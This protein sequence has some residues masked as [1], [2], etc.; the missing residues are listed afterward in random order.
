LRRLID[1]R[2]RFISP[3]ASSALWERTPRC[4]QL[5]TPITDLEP[6]RCSVAFSGCNSHHMLQIDHPKRIW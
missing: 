4:F 2:M 1:S 6:D 3:V 5:S